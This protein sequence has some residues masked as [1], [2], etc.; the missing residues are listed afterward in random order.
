MA[1]QSGSQTMIWGPAEVHKTNIAGCAMINELKMK[2]DK[3]KSQ[4]TAL[5]Y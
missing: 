4:G 2:N 1:V 5:I 3:V